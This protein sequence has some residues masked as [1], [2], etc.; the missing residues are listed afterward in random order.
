MMQYEEAVSYIHSLLA[1]GIQPGLTRIEA[2]LEALGN[3]HKALQFIHVAGT[4]GKGSTST[5]LSEILKAAGKKTG[6]FTSPYVYS[7]CERMQINNEN[8]SETELATVVGRVKAA[9]EEIKLKGIQPTEFEAITA[10][11]MLWFKEKNCDV[12]VLE[13]GLGGRLD[14]T[15]VI[16]TPLVTVITSISLDH[17]AILGDTIEKIAAEKAG[18]IKENA[19]VV[20]T[21]RQNPEALSVLSKKAEEMHGKLLVAKTEKAEILERGLQKTVF[22]Y[23]GETYE[24]HL[25]GDYQ[26]ENA[27][28]V[29][30][31]AKTLD[32]VTAEQIKT[33]IQNTV[34]RARCEYKHGENGAP[35]LLLDGG[36]NPECAEALADL[37]KRFAPEHVTAVIGMMHD[38]DMKAYLHTVL[39]YC[40]KVYFTKPKNPRA[41]ETKELVEAAKGIENLQIFEEA[42]PQIAYEKARANTTQDGLVLLCG[43]FYM[44]SEVDVNHEN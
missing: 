41:A 1:F 43:S 31:A 6:L 19:T 42:K 23:A 17:T 14:S 9:I 27:V 24:M 37:L 11:A 39:P 30:E 28:G 4:N 21:N 22:C 36:H 16:D 7:F 38:K 32:F 25:A 20:T 29:I 2:L 34:M 15:N 12:V 26:I 33:G 8:I 40:D 5:M 10:A 13:T 35:S 44:L 18:I 3:P